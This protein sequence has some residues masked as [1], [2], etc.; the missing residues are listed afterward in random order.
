MAFKTPLIRFVEKLKQIKPIQCS[1]LKIETID[2]RL[3]F[4]WLD[5]YVLEAEKKE[6]EYHKV[7]S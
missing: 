2:F 4:Y 1:T 3:F 5:K 7:Y 6:L